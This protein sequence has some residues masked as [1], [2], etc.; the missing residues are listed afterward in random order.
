MNVQLLNPGATALDQNDQHNHKEH[1]RNDPDN[2][3]CI[4]GESPF[5]IIR[6][7]LPISGEKQQAHRNSM[8]V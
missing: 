6:P 5:F 8:K 2:C 4:H 1:T 7:I 3:W